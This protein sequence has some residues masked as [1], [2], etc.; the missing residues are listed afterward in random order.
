MS[1]RELAT[2][3]SADGLPFP[4]VTRETF[5][6]VQDG[7]IKVVN[8]DTLLFSIGSSD[9][10]FADEKLVLVNRSRISNGLIEFGV[11]RGGLDDTVRREDVDLPDPS[12]SE[13]L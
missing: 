6:L 10:F 1:L 3:R 12:V 4:P 13:I 11:I 2:V 7:P 8:P 5:R 9:V